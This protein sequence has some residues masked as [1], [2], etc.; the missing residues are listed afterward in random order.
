VQTSWV[1]DYSKAEECLR[2]L[3]HDYADS[4]I[5]KTPE[6]EYLLAAVA[7]HQGR[8]AESA[9]IYVKLA[10]KVGAAS[11]K[12]DLYFK[13]A[14][15]LRRGGLTASARVLYAK[16]MDMA[17]APEVKR[18]QATYYVALCQGDAKRFPSAIAYLKRLIERFPNSYWAR[19]A[20]AKLEVWDRN[21]GS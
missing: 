4:P 14:N 11:R 8:I 2:R 5:A 20:M 15:T 16:V 3:L 6:V 21:G 1:K 17:E 18:A 7:E 13:A 12:A 9:S 19:Q 10:A